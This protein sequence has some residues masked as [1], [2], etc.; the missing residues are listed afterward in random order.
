VAAG[1]GV[2]CLVDLLGPGAGAAHA[3]AEL[4]VVEVSL[5]GLTD[6]LTGMFPR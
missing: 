5:A 1:E 3:A 2:E 4:G 6:R